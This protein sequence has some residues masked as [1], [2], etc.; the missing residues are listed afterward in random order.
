MTLYP[1]QVDIQTE[2]CNFSL[3][4]KFNFSFQD[5]A[6]RTGTMK[7]AQPVS[8]LTKLIHQQIH[9]GASG[10]SADLTSLKGVGYP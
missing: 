6:D 2:P 9:E 8:V 7:N 10:T 4:S 3:K 5:N 1:G